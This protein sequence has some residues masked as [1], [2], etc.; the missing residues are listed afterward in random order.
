M[1]FLKA[2]FASIS[3][4]LPL[5]DKG[6]K[7]V[8]INVYNVC[9]SIV[10]FIYALTLAVFIPI[11]IIGVLSYLISYEV[12]NW[13]TFGPEEAP[14]WVFIWVSVAG[15]W[16]FSTIYSLDKGGPAEQRINDITDHVKSLR[17]KLLI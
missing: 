9:V 13:M 15:I 7:Q 17:D 8:S 2:I 12:F 1:K 11:G 3:L 6:C 5:G 10:L 16:A 14:V 4:V